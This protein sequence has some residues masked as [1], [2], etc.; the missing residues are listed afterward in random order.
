MTARAKQL[1]EDFFEM[2][3]I[4]PLRVRRDMRPLIEKM[5]NN[6]GVPMREEVFNDLRTPREVLVN[7]KWRSSNGPGTMSLDEAAAI[8]NVKPHTLRCYLSG[9]RH[10]TVTQY[11]HSTGNPDILTFTRV[12]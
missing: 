4:I 2:V 10:Y 5:A 3:R 11:N 7:V 8:A 1:H 6:I 12:Q 9:S